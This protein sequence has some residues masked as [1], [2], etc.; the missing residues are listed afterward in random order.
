VADDSGDDDSF[1]AL[2]PPPE[3]PPPAVIPALPPFTDVPGLGLPGFDDLFDEV[4]GG[5]PLAMALVIAVAGLATIG[6]VLRGTF[7]RSPSLPVADDGDSL[8]FR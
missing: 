1:V 7:G 2:S 4:P 3:S 5:V 6:L 8:K